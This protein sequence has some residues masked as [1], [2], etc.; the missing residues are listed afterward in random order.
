MID[1]DVFYQALGATRP[2]G[3]DEQ[4]VLQD[5]IRVFCEAQHWTILFENVRATETHLQALFACARQNPRFIPFSTRSGWLALRS[6]C[7]ETHDETS[8]A[9]T[10][11]RQA[12]QRL[13]AEFN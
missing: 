4:L 13:E 1:V 10:Q 9:V 6:V 8:H 7:A 12:L 2:M 11:V 3:R 5:G